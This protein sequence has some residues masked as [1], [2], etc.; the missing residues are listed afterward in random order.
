MSPSAKTTGEYP[1]IFWAKVTYK[2]GKQRVGG[3]GARHLWVDGKPLDQCCAVPKNGACAPSQFYTVDKP[4]WAC[5]HCVSYGR[6][7]G[8]LLEEYGDAVNTGMLA[9]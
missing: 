8:L 1:R 4:Y 6:K 7:E 3:N 5:G 9:D 2:S